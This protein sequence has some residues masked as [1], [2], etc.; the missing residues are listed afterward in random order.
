MRSATTR[1]AALDKA[2]DGVGTEPDPNATQVPS[3]DPDGTPSAQPSYSEKV[4]ISGLDGQT[5]ADQTC[6]VGNG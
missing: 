2:G 1:R 3:P 4:V 5:A 6:T